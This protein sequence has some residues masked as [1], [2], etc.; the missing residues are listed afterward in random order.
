MIQPSASEMK[1]NPCRYC[2]KMVRKVSVSAGG[3]YP[4][5]FDLLPAD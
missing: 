4:G 5:T 1:T 2:M 3:I